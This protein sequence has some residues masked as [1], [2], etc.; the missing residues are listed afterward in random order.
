MS[1]LALIGWAY[2]GTMRITCTKQDITMSS[3]RLLGGLYRRNCRWSYVT[4][5]TYTYDPGGPGGS[6]H[7]TFAVETSEGPVVRMNDAWGNSFE[8][9]VAICNAHTPH[10]PYIWVRPPYCPPRF[11]RVQR[12][13][14]AP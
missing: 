8:E 14:G 7:E 10:L 9:F 6:A 3:R 12:N 13:Q 2:F 4:A 11:I 5:T 1:A